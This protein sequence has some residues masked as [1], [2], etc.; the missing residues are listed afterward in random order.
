LTIRNIIGCLAISNMKDINLF[1]ADG[2]VYLKRVCSKSEVSVDDNCDGYLVESLEKEVRRII[3][4]LRANGGG[5]KFLIGVVGGGDAF[6]RRVVETLGVDYLVS[7]E[8]EGRKSEGGSRK[9][10][11]LKQRDSGLNHVVAKIAKEKGILVVVDMGEVK[12]LMSQ[13]EG[14]RWKVEGRKDVALRLGRIMQNVRVCRKAGC[15]IRIGSFGMKKD[16]VFGE[17][18]RRAFGESLGM[19]SKQSKDAV[20]F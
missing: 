16:E 9:M 8:G 6:N 13:V 18:E 7:P 17:R 14:G 2:S 4:S 20:L 15:G 11:S 5:K 12:R 19:S 1:R 3:D 10:D